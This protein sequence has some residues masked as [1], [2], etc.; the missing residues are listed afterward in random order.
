MKENLGSFGITVLI[1]ALPFSSFAQQQNASQ[2]T[3]TYVVLG[4]LIL[5]VCAILIY[6]KIWKSRLSNEKSSE[7]RISS[8]HI[9]KSGKQVID[10]LKITKK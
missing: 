4:I 8:F 9:T 6:Y 10:S 1:L 3:S 7:G 2:H 5:L